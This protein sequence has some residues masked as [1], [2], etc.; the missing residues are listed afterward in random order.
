[1][2]KLLFLLI[3]CVCS[4]SSSNTLEKCISYSSN[5]PEFTEVSNI[6]LSTYSDIIDSS[7]FNV[8]SYEHKFYLVDK[9]NQWKKSFSYSYFQIM[10]EAA[11]D[12]YI[13]LYCPRSGIDPP[14]FSKKTP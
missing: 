4:C 2:N 1:M 12:K 13:L 14:L 6:I 3:I 7:E 11:N 9:K 8:Y 10:I 5:S